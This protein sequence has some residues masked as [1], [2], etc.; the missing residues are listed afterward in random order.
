MKNRNIRYRRTMP[1]LL[2]ALTLGCFPLLP[3]AQADDGNKIVGLWHVFYT[4]DVFGPFLEAYDQ[5]HSDG[6]EFE[7]ANI[8]PRSG[9]GNV[10]QG[11]WKKMPGGGVK[12]FHVGW[13]F[14]DANA[15]FT[16]P[17]GTQISMIC[18]TYSWDAYA[19]FVSELMSL[20][21]DHCPDDRR[22]KTLLEMERLTGAN[23]PS[24]NEKLQ[25]LEI[26]VE[27]EAVAESVRRNY[28]EQRKLT[29]PT[30]LPKSFRWQRN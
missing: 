22:V 23:P 2:I 14:G 28:D 7:V 30:K 12:V 17:L 25:T 26:Y 6:Q 19:T 15:P 3:A 27:D 18:I 10:C 13:N 9:L 4:S 8:D 21:K 24:T 20:L 1:T 16:H 5:W 11:T 29:S